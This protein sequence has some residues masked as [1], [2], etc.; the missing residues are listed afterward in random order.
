M[1]KHEILS[2]WSVLFCRMSGLLTIFQ[3]SG[4]LMKQKIVDASPDIL[5]FQE[6]V[7]VTCRKRR[8]RKEL[9]H[10]VLR[11]KNLKLDPVLSLLNLSSNILSIAVTFKVDFEWHATGDLKCFVMSRT[12]W[13]S[14]KKNSGSLVTIAPC[15]IRK[16][17]RGRNSEAIVSWMTFTV[18]ASQ[19][20]IWCQSKVGHCL[21]QVTPL[22]QEIFAGSC[23]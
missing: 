2:F 5:T 19:F 6:M 11:M 3:R 12:I 9:V 13:S 1:Y 22:M 21:R 23:R 17:S 18:L 20:Y 16:A 10:L 7:W 8:K 4:V 15:Q 14:F